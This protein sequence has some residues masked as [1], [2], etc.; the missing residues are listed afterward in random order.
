MTKIVKKISSTAAKAE[1]KWRSHAILQKDESFMDY[2]QSLHE[3]TNT[4]EDK[5]IDMLDG[6][7]ENEEDIYEHLKSEAALIVGKLSPNDQKIISAHFR[8]NNY[9]ALAEELGCSLSWAWKQ[10]TRIL[11]EI[12][13]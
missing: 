7:E 5:I 9:E 6:T 12:K 10:V 1:R 13:K 11:K 4:E 8:L 3:Y 2:Y